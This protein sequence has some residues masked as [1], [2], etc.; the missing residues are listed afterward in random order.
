MTMTTHTPAALDRLPYPKAED[1]CTMEE[2]ALYRAWMDLPH[3]T[4]L[5]NEVADLKRQLRAKTA[6]LR[7]IKA[8]NHRASN[9][10]TTTPGGA[11]W[12]KK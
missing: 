6:E 1:F 2:F 5:E 7:K 11:A 3:G 4:Y 12:W 9:A 8:A 10:F